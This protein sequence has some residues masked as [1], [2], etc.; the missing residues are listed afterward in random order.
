MVMW[1]THPVSSLLAASCSGPPFRIA[2]S[3][4][5]LCHI[6]ISA[7]ENRDWCGLMS[8]RAFSLV[9][10]THQAH[11]RMSS[12]KHAPTCFLAG[13]SWPLS[14]SWLPAEE[15]VVAVAMG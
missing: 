2:L 10:P 12:T 15:S 5:I 4:R 3:L 11:W 1:C 8:L 14:R 9:L 13:Y 7:L 6:F